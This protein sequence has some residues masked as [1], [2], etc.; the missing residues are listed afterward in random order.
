MKTLADYAKGK[1]KDEPE[2]KKEEGGDFSEMRLLR[3]AERVFEPSYDSD[4]T[5]TEQLMKR[6]EALK[7][8]IAACG[9]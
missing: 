4:M 8:L 5:R 7:L 1:S 6:V 3:L 2:E 9:K